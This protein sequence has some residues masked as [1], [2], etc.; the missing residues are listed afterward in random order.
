[1]SLKNS[2]FKIQQKLSVGNV[3][4]STTL[5]KEVVDLLKEKADAAEGNPAQIGRAVLKNWYTRETGK[6]LVNG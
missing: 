5:P 2:A 3:P 6:Q 4:F 1:M